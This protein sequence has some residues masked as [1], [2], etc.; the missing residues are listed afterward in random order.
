MPAD[1]SVIIAA[2]NMEKYIGRAIQSALDQES[3]SVEVIVVDDNSTDG[4]QAAIA[5][6]NDPRVTLISL[7]FNGGPSAARNAGFAAATAPWIAIL[8]SDDMFLQGRLARCLLR[9]K[10]FDADIVVDNLVVHHEIDKAEH[11]MFPP[12]HFSRLGVLTL[13]N[14]I[15]VRRFWS[16]K[17]PPALLKPLFRAEFLRQHGLRYD[18]ALRIAEDYLLMCEALASGARCAVE[19]AAGYFYTLRADLLCR[20]LTLG[21]VDRMAEA[22]EKFVARYKLSPAA[23]R[24][25]RRQ[26]YALKE[27]YVF[28]EL[29]DTLKQRDIKG[30]LRAAAGRPLAARH[31][32]RPAWRRVERL[33][34]KLGWRPRPRLF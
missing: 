8:D 33:F 26:E 19:P 28:A 34:E 27:Y 18:P 14:F 25:Q 20:R 4:T 30:A 7:P 5:R 1:I 23:A 24:L 9:A 6:I 13:E 22:D 3:V 21:D 29:I 12:A 16:R 32:W 31:L 10:L 2:Y 11:P 17:V 15:G